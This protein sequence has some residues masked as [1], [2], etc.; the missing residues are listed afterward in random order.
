MRV[1]EGMMQGTLL[2]RVR[3]GLERVADASARLSS[4]QRIQRPSQDPLA[5]D[6]LRRVEHELQ[7]LEDGLAK[8]SGLSERMRAAE[9]ALGEAGEVLLRVYELCFE[10]ANETNTA[11]ERAAAAVEVR[12]LTSALLSIANTDYDGEYLFGGRSP[13]TP[14]FDADGNFVGDGSVREVEV[15]AGLRIETTVSGNVAFAGAGGGLDVFAVVAAV[16]AALD[17]DDPDALPGLGETV[18][19]LRDQLT[20]VRAEL[21]GRVNMLDRTARFT[22]QMKERLLERRRDV[23]ETDV[24]STAA[25]FSQAEQILEA[26]L[27]VAGRVS[28]Q[29]TLSLLG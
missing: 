27:A 4:G 16:E 18:R 5:A 17:A 13:G 3:Q 20:N 7:G 14:P 12:E 1:T 21:G 22:G 6:A 8:V 25:E 24:A 29:G 9:G 10:V 11:D 28:S 2:S 19:D 15:A 26:A 23:A